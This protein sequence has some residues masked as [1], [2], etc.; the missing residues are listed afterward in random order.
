MSSSAHVSSRRKPVPSMYSMTTSC[1]YILGGCVDT[2]A[3]PSSVSGSWSCDSYWTYYPDPTPSP[4]PTGGGGDPTASSGMP[5]TPSET[6]L[7]NQGK[8]TATDKLNNL[9]DSEKMYDDLGKNG[10]TV[11]AN[12]TYRDGTGTTDCNNHQGAAAVTK[13]GPT[14]YC[15]AVRLS[16]ISRPTVPRSWSFTKACTRQ[17]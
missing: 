16:R 8:A 9:P 7:L 17:A 14:P 11:I 15:Y 10:P 12:T 13:V 3:G 5:L 2:G 1:D 4:D 6:F